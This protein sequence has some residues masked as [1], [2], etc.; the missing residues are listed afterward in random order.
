[1]K[2]LSLVSLFATL[3]TVAH[4]AP[5]SME[6]SRQ[7]YWSGLPFPSPGNLGVSAIDL[8]P[9]LQTLLPR[10]YSLSWVYQASGQTG[11]LSVIKSQVHGDRGF[12]PLVQTCMDVR[13]GL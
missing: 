6:F 4:Q 7:E 10:R 12:H 9:P 1:M 5:P 11:I 2:T 8:I 13:V 3:G